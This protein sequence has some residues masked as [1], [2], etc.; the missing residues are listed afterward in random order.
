[1]KGNIMSSRYKKLLFA[2]TV[3]GVLTMGVSF[4]NEVSVLEETS[5]L[6]KELS[7][8]E[9]KTSYEEL[10]EESLYT[11]VTRDSKTQAF[12]NANFCTISANEISPSFFIDTMDLG[13]RVS[14]ET[15]CLKKNPAN[16]KTIRFRAWDGLESIKIDEKFEGARYRSKL[17]T[18]LAKQGVA[19]NEFMKDLTFVLGSAENTMEN[20]SDIETPKIPTIEKEELNKAQKAV[21]WF[22]KHFHYLKETPVN[23]I[24]AAYK[25]Y[26][27]MVWRLETV[28]ELEGLLTHLENNIN[29]IPTDKPIIAVT[30]NELKDVDNLSKDNKKLLKKYFRVV[31]NTDRDVCDYAERCGKSMNFY[32]KS[33]KTAPHVKVSL[34]Q[35]FMNPVEHLCQ[36]FEY[37][38]LTPK[39]AYAFVYLTGALLVARYILNPYKKTISGQPAS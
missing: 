34:L 14:T 13:G 2:T 1:M 20:I 36:D 8:E 24:I 10:Y 39:I 32:R 30:I 38:R 17:G 11:Q 31:P 7:T 9:S 22:Q 4:A 18:L 26:S 15:Q 23:P 37:E 28:K 33:L 21:E 29:E 6:E 19:F 3:C 12:L 27:V 35:A 25:K 16:P 5:A